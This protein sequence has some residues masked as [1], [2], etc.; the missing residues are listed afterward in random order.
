MKK[1]LYPYGILFGVVVALFLTNYTPGTWLTGWDNLHSEFNFK[2]NIYRS[3]FS[4]WQEYQ[5]LGLLAGM[6]HASDI[7][8]QLFLWL[9]SLILPGELI[10]YYYHFLILFAGSS[11]VYTFVTHILLPHHEDRKKAGF[12]AS[13]F[14][15][16]NLG[17][18]QYMY[19]P[20]EPYSTFL[21]FFPWELWALF[22]F[23]EHPTRKN[24]ALF[25]LIN[26]A[27]LGQAYVQTVFLVYVMIVG[28]ILSIHALLKRNAVSLKHLALIPLTIFCVNAFWLMPNLYFVAKNVGVTQNAMQNRM[29]TDKFYEMN[30]NRGTIQD[31]ALLKEFY[32]DFYD[33]NQKTDRFDYLLADWRYHMELPLIK[34]IGYLFF[35]V[36]LAGISHKT[37]YRPYLIGIFAISGIVFLSSTVFFSLIN[38]VMR[39]FPLS[40]QIFRNPFTKFIVPA[41]FVFSV[42]FGIGAIRLKRI[43]F[44]MFLVLVA[45]YAIPAFKGNYIAKQMRVSIPTQY[46]ELFDYFKTQD[47]NA[48]IMNLPQGTYWGWYFYRWGGRGSGFLWYGIEQPI[49][50]RA[51]DVWSNQLEGYYWELSY[52]LKKRDVELFNQVIKKY[53][54]AYVIYDED[55]MFSDH[56]NSFKIILKQ[57][58]I[59]ANNPK[60]NHVATFGKISVY[61]TNLKTQLAQNLA[62]GTNL[63]SANPPEKFMLKDEHFL[64]LSTYSSRNGEDGNTLL[65]PFGS[66]FTKRFQDERTF[67]ITQT[68]GNIVLSTSIPSGTYTLHT[69]SLSATEQF[70]PVEIFA[71]RA[72]NEL[73]LRTQLITPVVAVNNNAVANSL[74]SQE[75]RISLTPAQFTGSLFFS[76]NN[77]DYFTISNLSDE[78]QS[79]GRTHF[80]NSRLANY[81]RVYTSVNADTAL[82]TASKFN[83]AQQCSGVKGIPTFSSNITENSIMLHAK[84]VSACSTHT[85]PFQTNARS[86]VH[87]NFTYKSMTD[88]FPQYC[89]HSAATD[90][91]LNKKDARNVGFSPITRQFTEFF[92]SSDQTKDE[93]TYTYVLEATSD[94]DFNQEKSIE[95]GQAQIIHYPLVATTTIDTQRLEDA[96][97]SMKISGLKPQTLTITIPK[98][99]SYLSYTNPIEHNVYKK[100]PLN[101]DLY[102]RGP[103][104]L[105][106]KTDA[107]SKYLRLYAQSSS[108]YVLLRAPDLDAGSGYLVSIESRHRSG[109]PLNVNIFTNKDLRNYIYTFTS[110]TT[111]YAQSYYILPP[112]YNFD[113]GITLLLGNISYSNRKTENDLRAA[114]I[115]PLPYEYIT[116]IFVNN[117]SNHTPTTMSVPAMVVKKNLT[118]Y[119]ATVNNLTDQTLILSQSFHPGWKAYVVDSSP[120]TV[121]RAVQ[122]A[123]PFLFAQEIKDH[124]MINNWANGWPLPTTVDSQ[125]STVVLLF[126]PQYLQY[127]GYGM[128][129]LYAAFLTFYS[130]RKD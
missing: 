35:L 79:I 89:Y 106:E 80:N 67:G 47:K 108:S 1:R 123:F 66:M 111:D 93:G 117:E 3:L 102:M 86:L 52:A 44:V 58:D 61:K 73:V 50:D 84:N 31:F 53:H 109:F 130:Q 103:F 6:G 104:T 55:L 18:V 22:K 83:K 43:P 116:K 20:F 78:E 94:E 122:E 28:F 17:T 77:K 88:E 49:M 57:K 105:E 97:K 74:Y 110:K 26:I 99:S 42:G 34:V 120:F 9:I 126:W 15:L 19:V 81:I 82:I 23:L 40:N 96:G 125:Q 62:L 5:G 115:Y 71:K 100:S 92:E 63:P 59:L 95:Y 16:F 30:K 41:I 51:F 64:T 14:Y 39:A 32:Y 36:V 37:K 129:I 114:T 27:A 101:Y 4:V 72:G 127:L 65:Y 87:V 2:L 121:H 25:A 124:V 48:R 54:I 24:L 75:Q 118:S 128:F 46:F 76:A 33:Y 98:I 68:N 21:G 90:T 107:E 85:S 29:A 113:H 45:I 11:G 10:R 12:L 119:K 38:D 8:R 112:I 60:V 69:P 13:L 91:C 56:L 70:L 7:V